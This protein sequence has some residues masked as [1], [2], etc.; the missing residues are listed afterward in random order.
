MNAQTL[1]ALADPSNH[2]RHD[3][4]V[5]VDFKWLM[6]GMGRWID[7]V[8]LH[9]DPAYANDSVQCALQSGCEPLRRC[10]LDLRAELTGINTTTRSYH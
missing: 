2:Q 1:D 7:P 6:A 5:E 9:T 10:A 3:L 8:R 4:L